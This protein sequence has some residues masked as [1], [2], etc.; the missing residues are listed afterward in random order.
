MST[1][2]ENNTPAGEES[3]PVGESPA[4]AAAE[5]LEAL[6]AQGAEEA[7][8]VVEEDLDELT[9]MTLK[10]DEYLDL[11]RRTQ[12]D[13]ENFR[14]RASREAAAGQERG[15]ARLAGELIPALDNLDLALAAI[16]AAPEGDPAHDIARGFALVRDQLQAGLVSAGITV[17]RPQGE[18]VDYERHE[19][20]AK[21]E[22]EGVEAGTVVEV[23]QSGYLIGSNV[24]RPARVSVAG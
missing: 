22:A 7:A 23:H 10:A 16:A 15:I 21:V 8:E 24:I 11:A 20:I 18:T 6:E 9:A 5:E 3:A 14:K 1:E 17:E 4:E 12:A 13:F 2:N 19:A